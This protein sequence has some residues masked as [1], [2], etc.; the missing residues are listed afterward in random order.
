MQ[1][2][3]RERRGEKPVKKKKKPNAHRKARAIRIAVTVG[4]ILLLL[5]P[6]YLAIGSYIYVK[7]APK[8]NVE[9]YYT[10]ISVIGPGGSAALLSPDNDSELFHCFIGM[11][12]SPNPVSVVK[13]GHTA[14][15]TVTFHTNTGSERYTFHFSP[16]DEDVYFTNA[17]NAIF[18]VTNGD[19][20]LF[21]NSPL[22]YEV[23]PQATL[24]ILQPALPETIAPAD[25]DWRYRTING[26]F[27]Q[28]KNT[29]ASSAVKNYGI[30]D[31]VVSFLF[32]N[33]LTG[34]PFPPDDCQLVITRGGIEI[35]NAPIKADDLTVPLTL[36]ALNG[37]ELFVVRAE[38]YQKSDVNYYG[39]MVSRFTMYSTEPAIFDVVNASTATEG[40]FYLFSAVNVGNMGSLLFSVGSDPDNATSIAPLVFKCQS[41]GTVYALIPTD[42]IAAEQRLMVNYGSKI[43]YFDL[44]RIP[45][46]RTDASSVLQ[47]APPDLLQLIAEHGATQSD[48]SST[49]L[50]IGGMA[51]P[52]GTRLLPFGSTVE[53]A[54]GRFSLPFELYTD[55]GNVTA[56]SQGRVKKVGTAEGVGKYVIIDHGYGVYSWYCGLSQTYVYQ[57]DTVAVGQLLGKAGSSLGAA[58]AFLLMTTVGKTAVDPAYLR[59]FYY[60]FGS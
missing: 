58:D 2:Y 56:L 54:G 3:P 50:S 20:G 49:F 11:L 43:E 9:T 52:D 27:L 33:A 8:D 45:V 48:I 39:S 40:S 55:V 22:S 7:N 1:Q 19:G 30:A 16:T 51:E 42:M 15:Y 6:T 25:V 47:G 14:N 32:Q 44:S 59:S 57:G 41:S 34:A 23:Y 26:D 36:P 53:G 5:I 35:F 18:H 29:G 17:E 12:E 38:Y 60:Y 31:N 37:K 21:L 10:S 28:L 24:P 13:P 4:M 46:E